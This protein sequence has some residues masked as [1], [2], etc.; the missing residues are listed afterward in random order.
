MEEPSTY[1][2]V[3]NKLNKIKTRPFHTITSGSGA[4]QVSQGAGAKQAPK[5]AIE[6]SM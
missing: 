6:C 1:M 5:Y 4:N 2:H 3:P